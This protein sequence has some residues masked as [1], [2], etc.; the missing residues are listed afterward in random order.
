MKYEL[1][2]GEYLY[3]LKNEGEP[4]GYD[5]QNILVEPGGYLYSLVNSKL[6]KY[7]VEEWVTVED[8]DR[9]EYD[10]P[11]GEYMICVECIEVP[12]DDI[13]KSFLRDM[14]LQELGL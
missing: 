10:N 12:Y 7:K 6:K 9:D 8:Y 5:T 13:E 11:P 4:T 14:K 1:N 2:V 3:K